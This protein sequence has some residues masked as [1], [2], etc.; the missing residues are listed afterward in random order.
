VLGLAV[1]VLWAPILLVSVPLIVYVPAA[2]IGIPLFVAAGAP[3]VA[4]RQRHRGGPAPRPFVAVGFLAIGAVSAG[5]IIVLK[6]NA[7]SL[8][9]PHRFDGYDLLAGTPFAVWSVAALGTSVAMLWRPQFIDHGQRSGW[10]SCSSLATGV[11]PSHSDDRTAV[12]Q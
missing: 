5:W 10:T 6:A 12:R 8:G 11:H 2:F 3:F 1:Q 7:Q 9:H 4:G